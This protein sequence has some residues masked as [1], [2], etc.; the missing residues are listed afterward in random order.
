M[1][2]WLYA[3]RRRRVTVAALGLAVLWLTRPFWDSIPLPFMPVLQE[4]FDDSLIALHM[5]EGFCKVPH[6]VP[7]SDFR[8]VDVQV[9]CSDLFG[10]RRERLQGTDDVA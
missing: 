1:N 9:A 2:K 4:R 7:L 3:C 8:Q 10:G 6:L 5:Q